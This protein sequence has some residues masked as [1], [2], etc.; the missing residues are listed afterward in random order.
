MCGWCGWVCRRGTGRFMDQKSGVSR[1]DKWIFEIEKSSE[2]QKKQWIRLQGTGAC[3]GGSRVSDNV[4][5]A[6]DARRRTSP[7]RRVF[8]A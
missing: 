1:T 8:D 2:N 6:S 4:M 7:D 3:L 5:D